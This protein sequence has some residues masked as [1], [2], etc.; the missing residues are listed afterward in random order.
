MEKK[1]QVAV[2]N[3]EKKCR[4]LQKE[5]EKERAL[6]LRLQAKKLQQENATL[7]KAENKVKTL[8]SDIDILI[9][10]IEILAKDRANRIIADKGVKK[11]RP[12]LSKSASLQSTRESSVHDEPL[13]DF[14]SSLKLNPV[15]VSTEPPTVDKPEDL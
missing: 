6:S 12:S 11:P 10:Q 7:K 9:E 14:L 15:Y 1:N 8:E 4:L 2:A 3:L 5:L 13:D